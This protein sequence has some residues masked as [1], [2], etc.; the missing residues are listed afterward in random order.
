MR[1]TGSAS[2]A[3]TT[4]RISA[5]GSCTRVTPRRRARPA[6]RPGRARLTRRGALRSWRTCAASSLPAIA[7]RGPRGLATV[8]SATAV[9]EL[10]AAPP[11]R[12]TVIGDSIATGDRSTTPA[13]VRSSRAGVDLDLAARRLPPPRRR[14]LPVRGVTPPT[15]V[16]LLPSLRLG[17]TVVVAVGYN[18]YEST[19]AESVETV[20]QALEQGGRRARPLAHAARRAAVVP[21]HERHRPRRADAPPRADGRRLEPLLAKPSRLVPGRR[22]PSH[23]CRRD[24]AWRRSCTSRSTTSGSSPRPPVQRPTIVTK[25]L[26]AARV[27]R[28]YAAGSPPPAARRRFAG[29]AHAGHAAGAACALGATDG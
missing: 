3:S 26:P 12:V 7:L 1:P 15:L 10:G 13:L 21:A 16:D 20:L 2:S 27:G 22:A 25:T 5:S 9:G 29:C 19:F 17:S 14:Q 28:P 4:R 6:R 18:D 8:A 24:R 23:R 11:T